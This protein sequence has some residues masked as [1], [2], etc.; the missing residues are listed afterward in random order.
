MFKLTKTKLNSELIA[1]LKKNLT[2]TPMV[3]S[4][5]PLKPQSFPMFSET[6]KELYIPFAYGLQKGY[7]TKND[8]Q[9]RIKLIHD[10]ATKIDVEFSSDFPLRDYQEVGLNKALLSLKNNCG[11]LL[12]LQTGAGKSALA[13]AIIAKLKLKTLIIVHKTFLLQ[14][15]LDT[16]NKFLKGC[17]VSFIQGEKVDTSGDIVIAMLQSMSMKDYDKKVFSSFSLVVVDEVHHISSTCFSKA[18]T[19]KL[20]EVYMIGLSATPKRADGIKVEWLVSP[21]T[22]KYERKF[23]NSPIVHMIEYEDSKPIEFVFNR[24]GIIS[25]PNM[26]NNLVLDE[27]RNNLIVNSLQ[28]VYEQDDAE[29]RYTL[30]VSDRRSHLEHLYDLIQ[31]NETLNKY[32]VGFQVG[33]MRK[34]DFDDS[35]QNSVISL[36]TFQLCSEGYDNPKL[37]TLLLV[38]PKSNIQ[39]V[40][41]RILRIQHSINPLILDINDSSVYCFQP[42]MKK[43]EKFFKSQNYPIIYGNTLDLDQEP[44]I[45]EDSP[46]EELSPKKVPGFDFNECML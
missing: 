8:L 13:T 34:K 9:Q 1:E 2:V 42:A 37:N 30:V 35:L 24:A 29:L 27:D 23:Q 22:Y 44:D 21:I 41:G 14:Q 25:S 16:I 6:T 45:E 5:M 32:R 10:N 18:V 7:L 12:C 4:P 33:G 43:R 3:F 15:F 28:K 11:A 31:Q 19:Q 36:S 40:N 26:I 38:T 20:E 39:Q 46:N 17:T